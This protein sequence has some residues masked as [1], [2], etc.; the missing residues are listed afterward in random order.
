M[1]YNTHQGNTET[2]YLI[3]PPIH[4][5]LRVCCTRLQT[6]M[7]EGTRQAGKAG[8]RV[9]THTHT[10]THTGDAGTVIASAAGQL[11]PQSGRGA[12]GGCCEAARRL[13]CRGCI[14]C[15]SCVRSQGRG[16]HAPHLSRQVLAPPPRACHVQKQKNSHGQ[17]GEAPPLAGTGN[18]CYPLL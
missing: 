11:D 6:D 8:T 17:L 9:A 15:R 16:A 14:V 12:C 5:S 4:P 13:G 10:H 1:I 7:Q 18:E 3:L 2:L